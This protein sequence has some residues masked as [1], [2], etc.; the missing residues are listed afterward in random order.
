MYSML[1]GAGIEIRPQTSG[2]S[3]IVRDVVTHECD[4]P[5]RKNPLH[6]GYQLLCNTVHPSVGGM[7]AFAAPMMGHE[8]KTHAFQ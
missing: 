8:T 2:S 7:P 6:R 3:E 1:Q 4:D 5:D